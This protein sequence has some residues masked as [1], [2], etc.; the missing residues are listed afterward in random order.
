MHS[1]HD[2][3]SILGALDLP[4]ESQLH[5]LLKGHIQSMLE[6]PS[7]G[8]L[9]M[10]HI[11]VVE[12]GDRGCS[13]QAEVGFS[14]LVSPYDEAPFGSPAF[15]PF[16]DWLKGHGRWFEMILTVGNSGFAYIVFIENAAG[17]DAELLALCK[18]YAA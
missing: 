16:W 8:L 7:L 15:H 11:L 4:L 1:F 12:P 14:P 13:I 18:T 9:D 6:E 10:T 5:E 3:A 17:A 2:R